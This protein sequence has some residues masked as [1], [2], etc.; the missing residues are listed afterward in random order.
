MSHEIRTPMNGVIGMT[1][2]LLDTPLNAEQLEYAHMVKSSAESLLTIIN[3]I[4][5]FSKIE[6]GKLELESIEFRLQESLAP[7]LKTLALRAHQNGLEL[8]CDFRPGV[9]EVVVADPSRLRQIIVNLIGN[10]I[11]FTPQGEVGL[12]VSLESRRQDQ[13][14]LHFVVQDTGIGIAPEKA[15]AHLRGFLAGRWLHGA[16]FRG[17]GFGTDNFQTPG[18][19]DGRPDVGGKRGGRRQRLP[20]HRQPGVGKAAQA[21]QA[22]AAVTLAGLAVR[23]WT[24]TPP[25][26]AS[27]RRC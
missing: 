23:W 26:A 22:V 5:D 7:M 27:S 19:N 24:T 6:A 25:T 21:P 18:G 20:L 10:A 17:H 9:P 11:K 14:R 8:T 12:Q 13:V 3:D 2:L 4:L 15:E 16:Q 1:E